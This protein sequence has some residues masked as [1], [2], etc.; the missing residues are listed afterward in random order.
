M[1][2]IGFTDGIKGYKFISH[3]NQI[4]HAGTALFNEELFPRCPDSKNHD[5]GDYPV[6]MDEYSP[7]PLDM[8]DDPEDHQQHPY[9]SQEEEQDPDLDKDQ[10]CNVPGPSSPCQEPGS[11]PHTN[12]DTLPPSNTPSDD[13]NPDPSM[14]DI[15]EMMQ[16]LLSNSMDIRKVSKMAQEGGVSFINYLI[17]QAIPPNDDVPQQFQD[18]LRL[19]T[20]QKE[21]W[22]NACRKELE[23]LRKRQVFELCDLPQGRKAIKN[24]WIFVI[25]SD[26]RKKS[27]LS[28]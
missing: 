12:S 9:P 14:S 13:E 18:I 26:G 16:K 24:C 25:K 5:Q 4:F 20:A 23:A 11:A 21:E 27:A 1:T 15:E 22:L 10:G 8:Q 28:R 2:F 6:P 3:K 19:P 7:N 17:N